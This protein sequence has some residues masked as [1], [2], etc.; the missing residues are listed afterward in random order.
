MKYE[1]DHLNSGQKPDNKR[2]QLVRIA[3]H[4]HGPST[5]IFK[6]LFL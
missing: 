4:R 1:Q 6:A 2:Q 5:R 3:F